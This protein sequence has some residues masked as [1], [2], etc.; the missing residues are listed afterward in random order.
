MKFKTR[1][2]K[3][4]HFN[5][6]I[7]SSIQSTSSHTVSAGS[8]VVL[9]SH[10]CLCLAPG[11]LPLTKTVYIKSFIYVAQ[12][13]CMLHVCLILPNCAMYFANVTTHSA[14]GKQA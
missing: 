14:I 9:P 7:S 8:A 11:H 2:Q 13:P 10:P 4:T 6:A 12:S 5:L 1:S 3:P